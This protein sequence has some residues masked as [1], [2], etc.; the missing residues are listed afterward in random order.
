MDDDGPPLSETWIVAHGSHGDTPRTTELS[1]IPN[2]ASENCRRPRRTG[3]VAGGTTTVGMVGGA[4][5]L[6]WSC[7]TASRQPDSFFWNWKVG[8]GTASRLSMIAQQS[9]MSTTH[10]R[11]PVTRIGNPCNVAI[12]SLPWHP[13]PPLSV[14]G[15]TGIV[16]SG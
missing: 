10:H 7:A 15:S 5:S 1:R 3:G 8:S 16:P 9:G 2:L 13:Q 4:V 6:R 14:H 12:R 11:C